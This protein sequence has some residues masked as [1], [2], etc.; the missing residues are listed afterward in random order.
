MAQNAKTA[1]PRRGVRMFFRIGVVLIAFNLFLGVEI[2]N[3]DAMNPT[4]RDGQ[5]IFLKKERYSLNRGVPKPNEIVVIKQGVFPNSTEGKPI[6]RVAGLPG[7]TVI[8][9]DKAVELAPDEVFVAGDNAAAE[10]AAG[11]IKLGDIRGRALVVLWPL[12]DIGGVR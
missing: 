7:E 3:G 8:I 10:A 9:G 1:D 11:R 12:S 2:H 6:R 5:L 4:L